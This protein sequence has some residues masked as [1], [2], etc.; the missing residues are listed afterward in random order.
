MRKNKHINT[1]QIHQKK[2]NF[3]KKKKKN[4]KKKRKMIKKNYIKYKM[5]MRII[6][7]YF[8]YIK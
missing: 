4:E 2:K 3:K 6:M 8:S 1:L 7:R 5:E